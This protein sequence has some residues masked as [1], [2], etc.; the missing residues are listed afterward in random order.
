MHLKHNFQNNLISALSGK[1]TIKIPALILFIALPVVS[2][3]CLSGTCLAI[4]ISEGLN[5]DGQKIIS[6]KMTNTVDNNELKQNLKINLKGNINDNLKTDLKIDDSLNS[7][8]EKIKFE[9]N[10]NNNLNLELGDINFNGINQFSRNDRKVM[11]LLANINGGEKKVDSK[12]P[13]VTLLCTF[14]SA[15]PCSDKFIGEGRPGPFKLSNE[16][17]MVLSERVYIDGVQKNRNIDY[18]IDCENGILTFNEDIQLGCEIYIT[19]NID[20]GFDNVNRYSVGAFTQAAS[21]EKG[22]TKIGVI[23]SGE[24]SK[25]TN[26]TKSSLTEFNLNQSLKLNEKL[27]TNLEYAH[28]FK[29]GQSYDNSSQNGSAIALNTKLTGRIVDTNL[30]LS[31][32]DPQY[33]PYHYGYVKPEKTAEFSFDLHPDKSEELNVF[34]KINGSVGVLKKEQF[35]SSKTSTG[36][37]NDDDKFFGKFLYNFDENIAITTNFNKTPTGS[38][39]K[40]LKIL[41]K[42]SKLNIENTVTSQRR[43][44]G[45]DELNSM[46]FKAYSFPIKKN[47]YFVEYNDSALK[48]YSKLK[49]ENNDVNFKVKRKVNQDL[50]LNYS[51]M[52]SR[53]ID[54]TNSEQKISENRAGVDYSMSRNTL[55]TGQLAKRY[56]KRT[57]AYEPKADLNGFLLGARYS[58][59]DFLKVLLKREFWGTDMTARNINFNKIEDSLKVI[60]ASH[61]SPY[62][63]ELKGGLKSPEYDIESGAKRE[64][65]AQYGAQFNVRALNKIRFTSEITKKDESGVT[66]VDTLNTREEIK[67]KVNDDIDFSMNYEKE[68]SI[69][70]NISTAFRLE[71]RL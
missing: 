17:I 35:E 32:V 36:D 26:E 28:S 53:R 51:L 7:K 63:L 10:N 4:E 45:S 29:E 41:S 57:F 69:F 65:S 20:T 48:T 6:Y 60:L 70:K 13:E 61:N 50:S 34:N 54:Y 42:S 30:R 43:N 64:K 21:S 5:L 66:G 8:V 15:K 12:Q 31:S 56:E 58:P 59:L 40:D 19:Y 25:N 14:E 33:S 38:D 2:F 49:E 11:G 18:G 3:F 9:Y 39:L 27:I 55:L 44:G 62:S 71:A 67:Y 22:N 23:R 68:H 47:V 24:S 46:S 1:I 52:D 37:L 16:K